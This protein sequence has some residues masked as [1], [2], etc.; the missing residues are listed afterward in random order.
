MVDDKGGSDLDVFEGLEK[1]TISTRPPSRTQSTPPPPPAGVPS[2]RSVAA[3]KR[4]LLGVA[5]PL[6]PPPPSARS[7]RVG[8]PAGPSRAPPPLP[9][10]SNLPPVV[11]PTART[12]TSAPPPAAAAGPGVQVSW[13][14]DD[15]T[16]HIF[17]EGGHK[18]APRS[19]PT[20]AAG[21]RVPNNATLLGLPN[22]LA[23]GVPAPPSGPPVTMRPP[24]PPSSPAA[25]LARSSG[26][27]A[28]GAAG[29]SGLPPPPMT[30]P[31][32]GSGFPSGVTPSPSSIRAPGV[33]RGMPP[34]PDPSG[35]LLL[36]HARG[37]DQTALVRPPRK[38]IGLWVFLGLALVALGAGAIVLLGQPAPGRIL[39]YVTDATGNP[40]SHADVSVDGTRRCES[41]PCTVDAVPGGSHEIK[42]LA[43][44]FAAPAAS[45]VTVEGSKDTST[46]FSLQATSGGLKVDGHQPG[47]KLYIDDKEIGPLPQEVRDLSLG[48]HTIKLAGS[49]RY[50]PLEKHVS[51]T[52]DHSVDL[53]ALA[54]KVLRGKVTVNPG[55]PG[56]RVYLVSGT[57]RRELPSL[58][59]SVDIDT[60]KTWSLEA[61]KA[62]LSDF[63]EVIG[64]DDG[65][66]EKTFVVTLAPKE[67]PTPKEAPAPREAPAPVAA[68][69]VAAAAAPAPAPVH[70][71]PAPVPAPSPAPPPAAAAEVGEA[72]LNINSIPP[73]TCFLDGHSLGT[74]P[75]VHVSVKPGTHVVKFINADQGL[76]K[77]VSVSVGAGETKPAVAKLN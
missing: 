66:A 42:V 60:T 21:G 25:M 50:Q 55:T 27:P 3:N 24:P 56:A 37:L 15:E 65:V 4:T 5:A 52:A 54:L 67:A 20:P 35:T 7:S 26:Y 49:D 22:P 64:F 41:A 17:E 31:G 59:I 58:P 12:S 33:P 48:D 53:G 30:R 69:P 14:E 16:T 46:K 40:V 44:G 34:L 9:G 70:Q 76:T 68:A 73:S 57:D 72:F 13:D 29:H 63:K 19:G 51:V 45:T 47:V 71:A 6:P 10:R 18:P 23:A 32:L 1:K 61:S 43:P 11:A 62:G 2:A 8:P 38:R 36:P 28:A 77:T 75:R 39:V 74:T